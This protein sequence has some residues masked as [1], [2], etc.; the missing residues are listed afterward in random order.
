VDRARLLST[1]STIAW[2]LMPQTKLAT[3][4]RINM[5]R[6]SAFDEALGDES[7]GCRVTNAHVEDEDSRAWRRL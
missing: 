4:A 5:I 3:M 7:S 6:L 1:D 2:L